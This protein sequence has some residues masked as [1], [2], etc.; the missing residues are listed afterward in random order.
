MT[1]PVTFWDALYTIAP[2]A[3][4]RAHVAWEPDYDPEGDN[5][6]ALSR[7]YD[8]P[9]PERIRVG[10]INHHN[11]ISVAVVYVYQDGTT[12]LVRNF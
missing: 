7:P 4:R 9:I 5:H 1:K 3:A 10:I 2:A 12:E 11:N 8:D 6:W